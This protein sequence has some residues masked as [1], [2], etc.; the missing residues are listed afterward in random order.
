MTHRIILY[1]SSTMEGGAK[2]NI[3]L[4]FFLFSRSFFLL[5]E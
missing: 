3:Y 1:H 2:K 5:T 4:L